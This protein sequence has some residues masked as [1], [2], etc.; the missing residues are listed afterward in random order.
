MR[1]LTG[2]QLSVSLLIDG[3]R[4]KMHKYVIGLFFAFFSFNSLAELNVGADTNSE[5]VERGGA[6]VDDKVIE[7]AKA[8][9]ELE[10]LNGVYSDNHPTIRALKHKIQTL[11]KSD[12]NDSSVTSK[13][14]N[15]LEHPDD[16][17]A[18]ETARK[19]AELAD[20]AA[21]LLEE[22]SRIATKHYIDKYHEDP[23]SHFEGYASELQAHVK[24]ELAA[25]AAEPDRAKIDEKY[26]SRRAEVNAELARDKANRAREEVKYAASNSAHERKVKEDAKR[27]YEDTPFYGCVIKGMIAFTIATNK[28]VGN[29]PKDAL[30]NV[31]KYLATPITGKQGLRIAKDEKWIK[32]AINSIYKISYIDPSGIQNAVFN[33]CVSPTRE[34]E[35]LR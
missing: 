17:K 5:S 10:K 9:S 8:K 14:L 22:K 33:Q 4:L 13:K 30:F 15:P 6:L 11:E 18:E 24:A 29:A 25:D 35:E 1:G 3:G 20:N 16:I 31:K 28:M 26:A 19:N 12:I 27:V 32:N 7:L 23:I 2:N 34:Y 21:S